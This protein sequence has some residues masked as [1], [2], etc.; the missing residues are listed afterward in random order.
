MNIFISSTK[1]VILLAVLVEDTLQL[2]TK[3]GHFTKVESEDV[4]DERV[5]I[6]TFSSASQIACSQKCLWNENCIFIKYDVESE[7]C[8]LLQKINQEDF[9]SDA[10]L[11]KKE[12]LKMKVNNSRNLLLYR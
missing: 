12:E 6:K 5:S 1:F 2:G 4:V 10:L 3:Q 9:D 11:S 8:E 7:S